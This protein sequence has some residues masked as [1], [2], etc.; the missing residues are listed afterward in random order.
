MFVKTWTALMFPC[1]L[2]L[3][4]VAANA[5]ERPNI[6]LVM[7]D[8]LGWTDIG[9]YGS[10]IETPNLDMLAQQGM[11]F[12]DFH[13]SVSCSP[14][15]SMLLSGNDNHIAG[16]GTMSEML[17]A[18]QIGQPG[19]ECHLNDRV[20]SLAEVLRGAGYHTYMSG[21][22]HL[23]HEEGELPFDRG[24]E[25]SFTMLVG[26]ASHWDDMLGILPQDHPAP[27]AANGKHLDSLPAD[28]C[29][30][31]SY[32]DILIDQIRTNHGDDKPFLA[33][34][35]FT[36]PHDPVHVPE[37]WLSK[38]SGRYDEGYDVLKVRRW[39]AA[40]DLGRVPVGASMPARQSVVLPW[41]ELSDDE[42]AT[43]SRGMEVYAGMVEAM[44][45]HYGRVIDYLGD[46]G[47]LDITV[48]VF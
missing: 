44:D 25:S 14:T 10:E 21:K 38:Y 15:R 18:N 40:K 5:G 27:Y 20:A 43:E 22:W 47:E 8:D 30:S 4:G 11:L 6:L 46:I 31:R 36:A 7:A 9:A 37:P 24:F 29:S 16:L 28:F 32:V 48:I 26:G 35:A 17:V 2:A 41:D 12:T 13:A 33:Y 45:Y 3:L 39:N 1:C 19:Y 42:R 34:L 23:G